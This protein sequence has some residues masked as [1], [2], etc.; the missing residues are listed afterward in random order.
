MPLTYIPRDL[1][2]VPPPGQ[3][4]T[5]LETHHDDLFRETNVPSRAWNRPLDLPPEDPTLGLCA[6]HRLMDLKR[7][8]FGPRPFSQQQLP[9]EWY[10]GTYTEV[11]ARGLWCKMCQLIAEACDD[12]AWPDEADIVMSWIGD[13]RWKKKVH[14]PENDPLSNGMKTTEETWET[15]WLRVRSIMIGRAPPFTP[16][17]L[18]PVGRREG[19]LFQGRGL[20]EGQIDLDLVRTWLRSCREWHGTECSHW[21][22]QQSVSEPTSVPTFD[23]FI[24]VIDLEENCLVERSDLVRYVALSYVWGRVQVFKT[25]E[26][27]IDELRV[28]GGILERKP[29][30][31]RSLRD[32][33]TLAQRLGYRYIWIDSICIIQDDDT[34][35]YQNLDKRHQIGQMG[36]IYQYADLT[37][38]AASG[39]DANAGLPG[40]EA[41]T[42]EA[43]Q[44][45]VKI[46]DDLTIMNRAVAWPDAL[47][48]T[49][50]EER[51]WTYQER[52]LSLRYMYFVDG[53]V[54]FQ[55]QRATWS[56]DFAAECPSLELSAA[57]Q[58]VDFSHIP[59]E[60]PPPVE[61]RPNLKFQLKRYPELVGQYTCRNMTFITDRVNGIQ[62]I[63]NV[64]KDHFFSENVGFVHGMPTGELLHPG[65]LWRPRLEPKR[66]HMDEKKGR[67]L[68]PS[69]SWA[70]WTV[71]VYYDYGADFSATSTGRYQA[72]ISLGPDPYFL[73]L[74]ARVGRFRL[75]IEDRGNEDAVPPLPRVR[76]TRLTRYAITHATNTHEGDEEWI[77]S[78]WLTWSYRRKFV[79]HQLKLISRVTQEFIILSEADKFEREELVEAATAEKRAVVNV[80]MIERREDP[81]TDGRVRIERAGVGRMYRDAWY[82]VEEKWERFELG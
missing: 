43:K 19:E 40:V 54:H 14:S 80:M 56:E 77:G 4:V 49:T 27:T 22:R 25:R 61:L 36:K 74:V 5:R 10:L 18:V 58:V 9:P 24:R 33:M 6:R 13:V 17:D 3:E 44:K 75:M 79:E 8:D 66:I 73:H 82:G 7:S 12:I 21:L 32:A 39:E 2:Y 37:I 57:D 81:G 67:P 65:L 55:C 62:G 1:D 35:T 64:I 20:K 28:P 16:F 34:D 76:P 60:V 53:T 59:S 52:I 63:L 11:A 38:V 46:S 48:R 45:E 51:G 42:R 30:F 31:P 71:P 78:I 70:G 47:L 23:P 68:W 15:L 29:L 41:G 72:D 26:E 69:W 50:W